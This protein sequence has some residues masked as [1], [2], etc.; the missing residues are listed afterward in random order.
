MHLSGLPDV[1]GLV[2]QPLGC[3]RVPLRQRVRCG[4]QFVQ[5]G[6]EAGELLVLVLLEAGALKGLKVKSL[7]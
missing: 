4:Q 1:L 2:G 3:A 5:G 7:S 6:E